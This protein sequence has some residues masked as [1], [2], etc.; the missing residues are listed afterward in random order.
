MT[1][2]E[3]IVRRSSVPHV[4]YKHGGGW[5]CS[6]YGRP[7]GFVDSWQNFTGKIAKKGKGNASSHQTQALPEKGI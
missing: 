3:H 7:G 4:G 2:K 5:N 6:G 1:P